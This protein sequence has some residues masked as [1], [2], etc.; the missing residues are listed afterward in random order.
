ME[1]DV[2]SE[3]AAIAAQVAVGMAVVSIARGNGQAQLQLYEVGVLLFIA[4][5]AL[6]AFWLVLLLHRERVWRRRIRVRDVQIEMLTD[7]HSSAEKRNDALVDL[8]IKRGALNADDTVLM[9]AAGDEAHR[10]WRFMRGKFNTSELQVLAVDADIEWDN[11]EGTTVDTRL[12]NLI[13]SAKRSHKIARLTE[14][15]HQRRP[16]Q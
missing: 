6:S 3:K 14:L 4:E 13:G 10:L 12:A 11:V 1:Q 8:L 15:A 7:L 9:D 2:I 16:N 5:T